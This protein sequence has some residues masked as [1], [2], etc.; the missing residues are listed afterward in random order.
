MRDETGNLKGSRGGFPLDRIYQGPDGGWAVGMV[1]WD[2]SLSNRLGRFWCAL[3]RKKGP[4]GVSS[5]FAAWAEKEKRANEK[6]RW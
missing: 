3:A 4:G 1:T 6:C 2:R 5:R